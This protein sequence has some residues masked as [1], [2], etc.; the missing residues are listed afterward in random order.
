VHPPRIPIPGKWNLEVGLSV[1][2]GIGCFWLEP[3]CLAENSHISDFEYG[4]WGNHGW[5]WSK[6]LPG[7]SALRGIFVD[8]VPIWISDC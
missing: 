5:I 3:E 8:F 1:F 4:S 2:D 6:K 7:S